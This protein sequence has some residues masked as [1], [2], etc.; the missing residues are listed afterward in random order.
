MNRAVGVGLPN[1]VVA[2]PLEVRLSLEPVVDVACQRLV[3]AGA[4]DGQSVSATAVAE[5]TCRLVVD[6]PDGAVYESHPV[7]E[8][9][10]CPVFD[11]HD[12]VSELL[13][14]HDRRLHY[15]VILPDRTYLQPLIAALRESGATVSVERILTAGVDNR[16][17]P[18]LTAK[19]REAFRIAVDAGY[20]DRPRRATLDDIAAELGI[21]PSAVSQR[22]TGVKR[23]LATMYAQGIDD[24][25]PR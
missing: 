15:S 22:L 6:G 11:R 9:C 23:R 10:P 19:Q 24:P 12:C 25:L 16:P 14:V 1:S 2:R 18:A 3:P 5:G 4:A 17:D 20:Y 13:A 7:A 8:G 21:S